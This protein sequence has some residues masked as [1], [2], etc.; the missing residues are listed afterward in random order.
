[1]QCAHTYAQLPANVGGATHK[2]ASVR[3]HRTLNMA[4][5]LSNAEQRFTVTLTLKPDGG[6]FYYLKS[7]STK[8]FVTVFT[9]LDFTHSICT[10]A[11]Q[12]FKY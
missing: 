7:L 2:L 4:T 5:S 11:Q 10:S 9:L 1:M 6:V 8:I 3:P 12:C